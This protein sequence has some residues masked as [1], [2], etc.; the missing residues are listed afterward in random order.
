MKQSKNKKKWVVAATTFAAMAALA[1]T[2]AWLTSQDSA[3]N[4][5]EGNV[6]GSDVEVVET[7]TPPLDW[8][9]GQKVNKDVAIMNS[10]QYDSMI[11]VS[12]EEILSK[13][14]NASS[15]TSNDA[16]TVLEGKTKEQVYLFPM[17]K[18]EGTWQD[19]KVVDTKITV[20]TGDYAGTYT[21]KAKEQEITTDAGTTYRYASY[22]DN[23]TEQYY[24]K[25]GSY[26]RAEDNTLTPSAPEFKYVD[27]AATPVEMNWTKPVYK[28]T[29]TIDAKGNATVVAGSDKGQNIKLDF[30]NLSATP[31]AGKW[32]Y[33]DA[34]GYF[35]YVG[36][37]AA[38]TQ[39]P[40]LL[41]SVT[42]GNNAD[43]S[44]SKVK[45]DLIVN[46]TSI[47]AAKEAVNSDQWVKNTN[48]ALKDVLEG[49]F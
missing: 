28:P 39:T 38:L 24:A 11:R 49:L 25:A 36:I 32:Y 41:D 3:K 9:P 30:V 43:N 34:D 42:L 7:F 45:F 27:L 29:L 26:S 13:L 33:N 10:G 14:D 4:H 19:A 22:W 46:A 23:G 47:Q 31:T 37:V 6:A 1:G 15:K 16:A 40:Q 12:F 18:V 5:F 21:L 44:Y 48:V 35:Y 8:V 17:S 20:A 2:F